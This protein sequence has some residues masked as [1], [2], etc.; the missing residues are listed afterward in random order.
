MLSLAPRYVPPPQ[1]S[2]HF[3]LT[4]FHVGQGMCSLLAGD[5]HAFFLDLGAGTPIRRPAYPALQKNEVLSSVNNLPSGCRIVVVLSHPDSDH[6][7]LLDWDSRLAASVDAIVLPSRIPSL[8]FKSQVL[9]GRVYSADDFVVRLGS[10]RD[11]L[12][13]YRSVPARSDRNGECLVCNVEIGGRNA[14]LSGDY[15]YKRMSADGHAA[16]SSLQSEKYDALVVPHHGDRASAKKVP[17]ANTDQAIA[18]FSA[19]NHASYGH[20]HAKSRQAHIDR[21][22]VEKAAPKLADI[23]GVQLLP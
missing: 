5:E 6:W 16:L 7:R 23:V 2:G 15:V 1:S 10:G 17:V 8:A 13:V 20:P 12:R 22:Y 18:F 4:A 9:S 14:L 19:G 3:S 11:E 21:G